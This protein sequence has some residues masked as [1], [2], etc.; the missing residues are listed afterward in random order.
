MGINFAPR[1][2]TLFDFTNARKTETQPTPPPALPTDVIRFN[3][4]SACEGSFIDNTDHGPVIRGTI[5]RELLTNTSRA[6]HRLLLS[7]LDP[8]KP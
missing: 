1:S 4:V 6:P 3:N 8:N 2:V 5:L 7:T